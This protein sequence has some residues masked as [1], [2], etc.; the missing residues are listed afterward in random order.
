MYICNKRENSVQFE[1]ASMRHVCT[2]TYTYVRMYVLMYIHTYKYI[3][4]F[5]LS[6]HGKLTDRICKTVR[7]SE[8]NV[9]WGKGYTKASNKRYFVSF[10]VGH[11]VALR[12]QNSQ[13]SDNRDKRFAMAAASGRP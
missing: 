7:T 9:K 12:C 13:A 6:L 2:Y 1:Y 10:M 11:N 5:I 8:L 4:R 3:F